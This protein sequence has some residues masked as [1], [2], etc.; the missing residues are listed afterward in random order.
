MYGGIKNLDNMYNTVRFHGTILRFFL[1]FRFNPVKYQGK[2]TFLI[3]SAVTRRL[4]EK[5]YGKR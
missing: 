1:R 3:Y 5:H 2:P 4:G